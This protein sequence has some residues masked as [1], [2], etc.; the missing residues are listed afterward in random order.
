M[1]V[2][3][4]KPAGRAGVDRRLY[5]G[6]HE[7]ERGR[8]SS[9]ATVR[10]DFSRSVIANPGRKIGAGLRRRT[11]DIFKIETTRFKSRAE[12]RRNDLVRKIILYQ[13][14]LR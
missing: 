9:I 14:M 1:Y 2:R 5:R 3:G 6:F 12:V 10:R 11:C 13:Y 7:A 4:D 8:S